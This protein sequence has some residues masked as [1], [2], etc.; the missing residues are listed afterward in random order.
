MF[1][2][3][4]IC[5]ILWLILWPLF[6]VQESNA[7]IA[8]QSNAYIASE[9][10]ARAAGRL[11]HLYL[12]LPDLKIFPQG[13]GWGFGSFGTDRFE[14][15][16]FAWGQE[17]RKWFS[18]FSC[19][20]EYAEEDWPMFAEEMAR[21][22]PTP[23]GDFYLTKDIYEDIV[24]QL[25]LVC[26]FLFACVKANQDIN[27]VLDNIYLSLVLGDV[28]EKVLYR[29]MAAVVIQRVWVDARLSPYHR[30]GRNLIRGV[31]SANH[32]DVMLP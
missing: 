7:S 22:W 3:T 19:F 23:V 4:W 6:R 29:D 16:V 14:E 13:S 5:W 24:K 15:D 31:Y 26:H 18:W 27:L 11:S 12:D 8:S 21:W 9:S 2:S 32:G 20:S 25:R 1:V 28:K 10:D 17:A 30:W